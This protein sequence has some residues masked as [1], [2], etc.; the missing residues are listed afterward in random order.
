MATR[1]KNV[2]GP[3][4]GRLGNTITRIRYGKEVVYTLPEKVNVSSSNAAKTARRKFG[5]TVNFA[6][7]INSIPALSAVWHTVKIPGTNS[8]QRL[9]KNNVKLT[10]ENNLTLNNIITPPGI[11]P[12]LLRCSY[13]D[14]IISLEIDSSLSSS[15]PFEIHIIFYFYE[16]G[17]IKLKKFSLEY[18][19]N[20]LNDFD[21]NTVTQVSL[22]LNMYQKSL[23]DKYYHCI[24]YAA[25]TS[26]K[27][28][29]KWSSTSTF[30][31][32]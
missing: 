1:R 15:V 28:K 13:K 29:I 14:E 12:G 8:Y 9:I 26:S 6:K 22:S 24:L 31:L 2:L 7:F 23:F 4:S 19:H 17:E 20:E 27:G 18:I 3:L 11:L 25:L 10:G 5:L 16:P 32:K 30:S 21:L